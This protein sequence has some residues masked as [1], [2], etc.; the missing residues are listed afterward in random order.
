P[1]DLAA[2]VKQT[3]ANALAQGA[4]LPLELVTA[5]AR[6]GDLPYTISYVSSLSLKAMATVLQ[7]SAGANPFS[8]YEEALFVADLSA[9]HLVLLNKFQIV[10]DH[11]MAITRE[12]VP[13]TSPLDA[14][15]Y[16]ALAKLM[17]SIDGL[18]MFN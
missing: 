8:P 9:T 14:T 5:E 6:D 13:Q 16:D 15:D 10:P 12:F 11:A 3:T 1:N 7:K 2:A 18:M 17:G 4:L